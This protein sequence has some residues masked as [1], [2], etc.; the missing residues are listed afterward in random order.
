MCYAVYPL[1]YNYYGFPDKINTV[2]IAYYITLYGT[3]IVTSI[4]F[5]VNQKKIAVVLKKLMDI[6]ELIKDKK[7][8]EFCRKTKYEVLSQIAALLLVIIIAF[9]LELYCYS[10]GTLTYTLYR[11]LEFLI[12]SMNVVILLL[13]INIVRMMRQRY[14]NTFESLEEYVKKLEISTAKN[15]NHFLILHRGC[16]ELPNL[17]L[18]L[19][20][21]QS[22]HVQTLRLL[23]IEMYDPAQLIASHFGAPVLLQIVSDTVTCV[24]L[25]YRAF[26]FIHDT[27]ANTD[28]VQTYA[29]SCYFI[30][31]GVV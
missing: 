6:D 24:L 29:T 26:N 13:Y 17:S 5:S 3:N 11:G 12:C 15:T 21:N 14:K 10:D 9:P 22:N 25:F 16:C 28:G 18:Q 8:T 30:F 7:T 19:L 20:S 27:D 31:W 1:S 2:L 23:Y 4:S